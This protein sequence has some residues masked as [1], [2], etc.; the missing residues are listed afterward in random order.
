M[1]NEPENEQESRSSRPKAY[2]FGWWPDLVGA[3][4]AISAIVFLFRYASGF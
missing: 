2:E 4:I 1:N 3:L